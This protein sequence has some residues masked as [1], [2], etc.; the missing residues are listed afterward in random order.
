[1][2]ISKTLPVDIH[3]LFGV[4]F[5]SQTVADYIFERFSG[6]PKS[7]RIEENKT[8]INACCYFAK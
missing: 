8:I 3:V 4:T 5:P 2:F 7:A 6:F 1:L